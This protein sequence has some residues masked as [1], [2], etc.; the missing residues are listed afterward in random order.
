MW[1][2]YFVYRKIELRYSCWQPVTRRNLLVMQD[3]IYYDLM[4]VTNIISNDILMF[5]TCVV[6]PRSYR[7]QN[8]FGLCWE[9]LIRSYLLLI[10]YPSGVV[11]SIVTYRLLDWIFVRISSNFFSWLIFVVIIRN[12][13]KVPLVSEVFQNKYKTSYHEKLLLKPRSATFWLI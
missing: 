13:L 2:H 11:D 9:P 8:E 1:R 4:L 5:I 10:F 6:I 7:F 12:N 3:I